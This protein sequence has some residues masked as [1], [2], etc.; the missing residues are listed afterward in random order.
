MGPTRG[1]FE[2][3]AP[4][5]RVSEGAGGDVKDTTHVD[6]APHTSAGS[7]P[8]DLESRPSTLVLKV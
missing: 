3:P 6:V 4:S 2:E 5:S 7:I 8:S 1:C